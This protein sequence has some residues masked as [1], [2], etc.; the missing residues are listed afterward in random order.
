MSKIV[1]LNYHIIQP[2]WE[3]LRKKQ[4]EVKRSILDYEMAKLALEKELMDI[5]IKLTQ[6]E[7]EVRKGLK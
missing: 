5:N 7:E 4:E 2:K 1:H 3:D 6:L